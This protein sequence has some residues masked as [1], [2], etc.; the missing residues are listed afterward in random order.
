M[1]CRLSKD[2]KIFL[3]D[4][5]ISEEKYGRMTDELQIKLIEL[6]E[7]RTSFKVNCPFSLISCC[8]NISLS[9]LMVACCDFI[10]DDIF[11]LFR[12]LFPIIDFPFSLDRWCSCWYDSKELFRHN[13]EDCGS[14]RNYIQR[15]L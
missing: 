14:E 6:F 2:F 3:A 9:I 1:V 8:S 10:F 12:L 7:K 4:K 15:K 13:L 5:D 11:I